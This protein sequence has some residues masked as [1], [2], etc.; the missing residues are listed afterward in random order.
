MFSPS[1]FYLDISAWHN[2]HINSSRDQT[3]SII[4]GGKQ[5]ACCPHPRGPGFKTTR[6]LQNRFQNFNLSKADQMSARNLVVK[7][8]RTPDSGSATLRQL[9]SIDKR[10]GHKVFQMVAICLFADF[11]KKFIYT[12]LRNSSWLSVGKVT[13]NSSAEGSFSSLMYVVCTCKFGWIILDTKS[14]RQRWQFVK[15][16]FP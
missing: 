9:N 16:L 4:S 1:G 7:S 12:K 13:L 3:V 11:P 5:K 6:W 8:K 15:S 10:R 2:L 14:I